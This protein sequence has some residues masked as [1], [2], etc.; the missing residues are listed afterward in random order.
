MSPGGDTEIREFQLLD[1]CLG[2]VVVETN[3][4]TLSREA[5][6]LDP[7]TALLRTMPGLGL[8]QPGF[9]LQGV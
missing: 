5:R 6:V 3:R 4:A 1:R 7:D 8:P 9:L 2:C